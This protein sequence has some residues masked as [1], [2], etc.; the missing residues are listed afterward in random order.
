M[1]TRNLKEVHKPEGDLNLQP[2]Q[3]DLLL[4]IQDMQEKRFKEVLKTFWDAGS[5]F[6]IGSHK[7]FKQT[8]LDFEQFYQKFILHTRL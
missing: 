2:I 3:S 7:D 6:T 8:H 1:K 4:Q 5:A